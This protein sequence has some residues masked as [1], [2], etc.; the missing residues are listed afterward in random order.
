MK[1]NTNIILFAALSILFCK[2]A[3]AAPVE[4]SYEYDDLNRLT[5]VVYESD[6]R[7]IQYDYDEVGNITEIVSEYFDSD[8]DG[9]PDYWEVKYGLDRNDDGSLVFDN[10]P[11]GN[12]DGDNLTNIEE[13]N[14]NSDPS[15]SDIDVD[16]DGYTESE[17][18]CDESD[19]TI[20]PA[21]IEL[22]DHV[23]N[24]CNNW[25]DEPCFYHP[26]DLDE[27][28]D[29]DGDDLEYFAT[30]YQ[31]GFP[32]ADLNLDGDVNEAD[33][34]E[35]SNSFGRMIDSDQDGILD[36]GDW[37]GVD[38]NNPCTN[39]ANDNCDDNCPFT[40]NHDQAE[41]DGDGLGDACDF[42]E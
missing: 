26:G 41:E 17:G 4:M 28:Y 42:A 34:E 25:I 3:F 24:D 7:Y 10:G 20:H 37:D 21:A 2:S 12:P 29:V 14:N 15:K 36:D 1:K 8:Q 22:C 5:K 33:A 11:D 40:P 23:D 35:M 16:G 9:M 27:D 39:G 6:Y 18:D 19:E 32:D 13:F 31:G 38:F 30:E